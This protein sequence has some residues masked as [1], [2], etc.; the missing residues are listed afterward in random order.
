MLAC[1]TYAFTTAVFSRL[2]PSDQYQYHCLILAVGFAT[3]LVYAGIGAMKTWLPP[4]ITA[5]LAL[6]AFLH[7][8]F[9]SL[10]TETIQEAQGEKIGSETSLCE[11]KQDETTS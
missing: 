10:R 7:Y 1:L 8:A 6:S 5:A 3:F 4:S 11:R 9:P 2:H